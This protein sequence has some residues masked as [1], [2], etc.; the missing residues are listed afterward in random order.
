VFQFLIFPFMGILKTIASTFKPFFY[1]SGIGSSSIFL[2][3]Y[4]FIRMTFYRISLLVHP[5]IYRLPKV[6]VGFRLRN[7]VNTKNL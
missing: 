4:N 7:N 3:C 2:I 1:L 6:G 5:T